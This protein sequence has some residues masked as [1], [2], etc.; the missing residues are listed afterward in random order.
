[1]LLAQDAAPAPDRG[2]DEL[3][4]GEHIARVS[5]HGLLLV[6]LLALLVCEVS[7]LQGGEVLGPSIEQ[8]AAREG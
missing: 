5:L 1:M 8:G 4:D 6:M 3:F 7:G 2:G